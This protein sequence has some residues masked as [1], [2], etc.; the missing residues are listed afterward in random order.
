MKKLTLSDL[1]VLVA[2][3]REEI[4]EDMISGRVPKNVTSFSELHDHVDA[5]CYGGLCTMQLDI[6]DE[7]T[8]KIVNAAQDSVSE[9]LKNRGKASRGLT[10]WR[11][12]HPEAEVPEEIEK[13]P[14]VIRDDSWHNDMCPRFCLFEEKSAEPGSGIVIYLW[15]DYE[16]IHLRKFRDSPRYV[17]ELQYDG[18]HIRNLICTEEKD[19]ILDWMNKFHSSREK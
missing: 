15:V 10:G 16:Q 17:V 1:P 13:H 9:W 6:Q 18:S 5:N 12:E 11:A 3:M 14:A 19:I 8:M 7:G 2:R 4:L